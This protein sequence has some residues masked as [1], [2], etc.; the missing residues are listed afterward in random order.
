MLCV[1]LVQKSSHR[2]KLLELGINAIEHLM[3][4]AFYAALNRVDEAALQTV[5]MLADAGDG[6][7]DLAARAQFER[8]GSV[9]C[10]TD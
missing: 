6:D 4:P 5:L 9:R 3:P 10:S 1:A 8:A 2:Q 7:A